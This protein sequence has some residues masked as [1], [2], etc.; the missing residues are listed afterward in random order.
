MQVG[1]VYEGQRFPVW[2][3][4]GSC[5]ILQAVSTSPRRLVCFMDVAYYHPPLLCLLPLVPSSV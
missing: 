1:V 4:S 3:E 5:L 2:V